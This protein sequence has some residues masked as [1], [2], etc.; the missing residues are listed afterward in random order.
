MPR[1][2][3]NGEVGLGLETAGTVAIWEEVPRVAAK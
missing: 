3:R 1:E 2:G